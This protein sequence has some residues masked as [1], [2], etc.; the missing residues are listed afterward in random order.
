M[1][2]AAVIT[3]T[4]AEE[5]TAPAALGR[6]AHALLL[7]WIGGVDAD[8]AQ[9]LHEGEGPRP[10]SASNLWGTG[11]AAEGRVRLHPKRPCALRLTALTDEVA[12]ALERALPAPGAQVELD[13]L[14]FTVQRLATAAAEHPWAGRASYNE[15]VQLHT[16]SPG[17]GPRGVT[18][19]FASPTC[20][21]S[22]GRDMP[23][24]LPELVFGGYLRKWNAFSPLSLPEEALRYAAECV[25][26]GRYRL[27]SHLV[28]YE[29][30]DKGAHVGFTG[31]VSFRFLVGDAYWT[32]LMRLLAAYAFWAGTGISTT[33]G[34]G[35]TQALATERGPRPD[36]RTLTTA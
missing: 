13:G 36:E 2:L 4:P 18:L 33:M 16:L 28:S 6:A 17:P 27:R 8:L 29:A 20:F 35:Q 24:P 12:A 30:A 15:L 25:A 34:F 10:F 5:A 7:R 1:P 31:E 9:R 14:P 22:Q 3:L 11:R 19:R 23:L 32:R 21:R 26:L